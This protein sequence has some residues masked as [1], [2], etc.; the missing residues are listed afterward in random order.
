MGKKKE[1]RKKANKNTSF[2][3]VNDCR[4]KKYI[5]SNGIEKTSK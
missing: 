1:K 4:N 2:E 3:D 5:D